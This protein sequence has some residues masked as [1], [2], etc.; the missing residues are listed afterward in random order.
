MNK[1]D[2][3]VEWPNQSQGYVIYHETV[4]AD[5]SMHTLEHPEQSTLDST[6]SQF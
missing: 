3:F 4:Y 6:N 5:V 2:S 1:D